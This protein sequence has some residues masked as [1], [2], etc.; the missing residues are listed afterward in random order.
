MRLDLKRITAVGFFGRDSGWGQYKQTTERIDKILTYMSKT[1][2]FAEIVM[3]STYKPKVEGVKHIQIEPFTYIEMNKWCLHEFGNYVNSDY[4]LHFEDD[5]FPLNPELWDNEFL[6]YDYVGAPCRTTDGIQYS[7]EQI[8][9]G[10]FTLRSKRLLEYTKTIDYDNKTNEDTVITV[11]KRDEIVS[12][13][14]KICPHNIARN[15]VVQNPL[16]D[17]HTIETSFGFHSRVVH[18]GDAEKLLNVKLL[19]LNNEVV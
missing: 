14:M 5:G 3:V 18:M 8:G 1:I 10:G 13:G 15:F 11:R 16:D 7:E 19:N 4:G 12:L 6:N 9:G 2:D 17:N